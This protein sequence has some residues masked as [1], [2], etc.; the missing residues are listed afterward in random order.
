MEIANQKLK[1]NEETSDF[2]IL[3][4]IFGKSLPLNVME[5]EGVVLIPVLPGVQ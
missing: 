5:I 1:V 3:I 4:A 2:I